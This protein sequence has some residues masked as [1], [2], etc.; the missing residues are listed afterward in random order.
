MFH[1]AHAVVSAKI[2]S[3]AGFD[4]DAV[5]AVHDEHSPTE[6]VSDWRRSDGTVDGQVYQQIHE[7]GPAVIAAL[8]TSSSTFA[9][10]QVFELLRNRTVLVLDSYC[11][12]LQVA[13]ASKQLEAELCCCNIM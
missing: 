8:L 9:A 3:N 10:C 13:F 2:F 5:L 7:P 6:C 12:S 4:M 11:T 1:Y